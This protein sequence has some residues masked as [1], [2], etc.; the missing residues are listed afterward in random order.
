MK[1][2]VLTILVLVFLVSS[3]LAE[4]D[5]SQLLN[6]M[7]NYED[8]TF[9][10]DTDTEILRQQL[11]ENPNDWLANCIMYYWLT[12][13]S[14]YTEAEAYRKT[15]RVN[16]PWDSLRT[17]DFDAFFQYENDAQTGMAYLYAARYMA[18][19]GQIETAKRLLV[20][21]IQKLSSYTAEFEAVYE[22]FGMTLYAANSLIQWAQQTQDAQFF[23]VVVPALESCKS[24]KFKED[25]EYA[26]MLISTLCKDAYVCTGY[27]ALREGHPEEALIIA[28]RLEAM[29]QSN[30]DY[31]EFEYLLFYRSIRTEAYVQ[32]NDVVSAEAELSTYVELMEN[33]TEGLQSEPMMRIL[34]GNSEESYWRSLGLGK[35]MYELAKEINRV[36]ITD[37]WY[38]VDGSWQD[39]LKDPS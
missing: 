38:G 2:I 32:L 34:L 27:Y 11:A 22:Y 37:H 21:A 7:A 25:S 36:D 23:N 15:T 19:E 26:Q 24:L 28:D 29:C 16:F 20:S 10:T 17:E 35:K 12:N 30:D 5:F 33:F 14:S 13:S 1:R 9:L 39:L 18:D 31:S 3:G 8:T 4:R 6:R